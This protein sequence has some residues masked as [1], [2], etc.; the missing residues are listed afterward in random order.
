MDDEI[1]RLLA[2]RGRRW[3]A[4][5]RW[6]GSVVSTNDVL[7]ERGRRGDE[8]WSVVI[9][10]HQTGGRG[11]QGRAW[12][13]P[14]GSLHLSV[15]LRPSLGPDSAGVLPLMA[16]VAVADAAR[17]WGVDARLKWPNDLI[18]GG[19]K[20]G[21]VLVEG[22]SGAEG[23]ESVV[24]GIGVNLALEPSTAPPALKETITSV[25]AET[26][27]DPG[28]AVAAAAVLDRLAVWYDAL[29]RDG[30]P[31]VLAA[32]RAR[33]VPWWGRA[34]EARSGKAVLRGVVR[35]LD[36]RGA[37][38]LDLDDGSQRAVLSGEVRELR[39]QG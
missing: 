6:V 2:A 7:K 10:E 17:E 28:V 33:S 35:G 34:V 4:P 3:M 26:G 32:W 37:L 39:L 8:A 25:R 27:R 31:S 1:R 29:A 21:G 24:V 11:R 36:G 14:A 15:L 20:L 22:A 30:P 5:V 18:A 16:G 9:A 12:L 13:S 23:L 38:I 19:R